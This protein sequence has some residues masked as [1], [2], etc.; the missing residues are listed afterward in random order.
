MTAGAAGSLF[1]ITIGTTTVNAQ[2]SVCR[3]ETESKTTVA[4]VGSRLQSAG[5]K[6]GDIL[7]IIR[8]SAESEDVRV[9]NDAGRLLCDWDSRSKI[10]TLGDGRLK[11]LALNCVYA[12]YTRRRIIVE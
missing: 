8:S 7:N 5:C 6:A 2:S 10:V 1:L 12:G 4:E 3:V 11:V 9:L